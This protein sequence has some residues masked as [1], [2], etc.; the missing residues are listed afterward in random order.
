MVPVRYGTMLWDLQRHAGTP[1]YPPRSRT[2]QSG[3]EVPL[4]LGPQNS[5]APAGWEMGIAG[6]GLTM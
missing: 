5:R 3:L 2:R 4:T 1:V 6:L